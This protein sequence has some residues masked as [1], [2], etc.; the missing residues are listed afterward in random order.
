MLQI[1]NPLLGGPTLSVDTDDGGGKTAQGNGGRGPW[2]RGGGNP[3]FRMPFSP[4][5]ATHSAL[6][7]CHAGKSAETGTLVWKWRGWGALEIVFA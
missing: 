2:S 3:W 1:A 7:L 6:P 5:A 4:R